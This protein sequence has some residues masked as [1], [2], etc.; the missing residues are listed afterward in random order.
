MTS[1]PTTIADVKDA[2][3]A[4]YADPKR[5]QEKVDYDQRRR[6]AKY[7]EY[8]ECHRLLIELQNLVRTLE[9]SGYERAKARGYYNNGRQV[10]ERKRDA[11]ISRW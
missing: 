1:E 2:F 8:A 4:Y 6:D 11:N 3:A 9:P 7:A 10:I 5:K